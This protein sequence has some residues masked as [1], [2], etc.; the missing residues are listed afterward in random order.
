MSLQRTRA[1]GVAAAVALIAVGAFLSKGGRPVPPD[2]SR[3]GKLRIVS[4]APSTTEMLFA[5]GVGDCVVGVTSYCDYPREAKRIQRVGGFG[6]PNLE[7]LLALSPNL[8]VAAGLENPEIAGLLRKSDVQVLDLRIR[9]LDEMFAGLRQIGRAIGRVRQAEEVVARMQAELQAVAAHSGRIPRNRRLR[10]FVELGDH[11]VMTVG[12]SSFLDEVIA[13]AG[14]VNVAHELSQPYPHV[15][16]EKVIEWDPDVI[17]V[18][19]LTRGANA[20]TQMAQRIGWAKIS[21]VRQGR[22]IDDI[23][24]DL[25]L[26]PGPRL[27]DG[28][29]A[30][31]QRLRRVL[32]ESGSVGNQE[33]RTCP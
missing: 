6:A 12:G 28:V 9:N 32:P 25:I 20:A 8:V 16:P 4:L 21:A 2:K 14:G 22:I 23:P 13:R 5:L 31:A 33:S 24:P 19:H 18:G 7:M 11:P 3:D 17:V 27:I 30:L 15:S 26:R 29:K 1:I 10:V